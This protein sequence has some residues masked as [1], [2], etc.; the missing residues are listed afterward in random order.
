MRNRAALPIF[1]VLTTL[2]CVFCRAQSS[3]TAPNIF[4]I[5]VGPDTTYFTS[6]L[7]ADGSVDYA[8]ALND[9]DSQGVE[10]A[11][12]AACLLLRIRDPDQQDAEALARRATML[13]LLD[14]N[15]QPGEE[16]VWQNWP[17]V[18]HP[19]PADDPANPGFVDRFSRAAAQP[20]SASE[21]PELAAWLKTNGPAL[22]IVAQAVRRPRLFLPIVLPPGESSLIHANSTELD[23]WRKFVDAL[24]IRAMLRFHD[25]DASGALDDL[26]AV[27]KLGNLLPQFSSIISFPVA[28]GMWT[29]ACPPTWLILHRGQLSRK[30]LAQFTADE[31]AIGPFPVVSNRVG[32][33]SRCDFLSYVQQKASEMDKNPDWNRILRFGNRYFDELFRDRSALSPTQRD[34]ELE[35][36]D[37]KNA[38]LEKTYFAADWNGP[39]GRP[40]WLLQMASESRDAYSDRFAKMALSVALVSFRNAE[41]SARRSNEQWDW[42]ACAGAALAVYRL[43]HGLY[44]DA[45]EALVPK[46]LPHLPDNTSPNSVVYERHGDGYIIRN[47]RKYSADVKSK[48][49]RLGED[50]DPGDIIIRTD[51]I[52]G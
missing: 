29:E 14:I 35:A 45:L 4:G 37:E 38:E 50:Y 47:A 21:M 20:W 12:N 10:T 19:L 26:L 40:A 31:L 27:R 6:P 22:D 33:R 46:Y 18:A 30:Q 23:K 3:A 28:C 32:E 49:E 9:R 15:L 16:I 1:A 39:T 43:D 42:T 41:H 17:G 48:L 51:Q 7:R 25:G 5:I 11:N 2:F 44:P 36:L 13:R 52:P 24:C 8:A 34:T